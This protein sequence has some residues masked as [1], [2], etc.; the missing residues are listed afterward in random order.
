MSLIDWVIVLLAA[1]LIVLLWGS[2]FL[3][4][5]LVGHLVSQYFK[6]NSDE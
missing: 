5:H 3:F 6:E 1:P 2:L 4:G